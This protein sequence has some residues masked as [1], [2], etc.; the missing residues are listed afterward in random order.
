MI[1]KLLKESDPFLLVAI[2]IL[3]V[4]GIFLIYSA[5]D[6]GQSLTIG[7]LYAR[8]AIWWGIALFVGAISFSIPLKWWEA[9]AYPLYAIGVISLIF[10]ALKSG[11]GDLSTRWVDFGPFNIQPSEFAKIFTVMAC[12]R[13]LGNRKTHIASLGGL[14]VP[15][16]LVCI[17]AALVAL[18]P[19]LGTAIVF[20][21]ILIAILFWSGLPLIYLLFLI[22]PVTSFLLIVF[23]TEMESFPWIVYRTTGGEVERIITL[24]FCFGIGLFGLVVIYFALRKRLQFFYSLLLLVVYLATGFL[25]GPF[26]EQLKP[27]QRARI[28][29]FLRPETD[30]LGGGWQIIQSKVAIGS[31]GLIGKGF[32]EGTQKKLAFLPAQHTDFIFSILGEEFGYIGVVLFLALFLFA[33]I[34][35]VE[36]ARNVSQNPFSTLLVFG[37]LAIWFFHF[38]INVGMTLGIMPVTGLPLPFLSYG[39]SFLVACYFTL[40]ILLRISTERFQYWVGG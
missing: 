29:G 26:W 18:Q 17:P 24:W 31:G 6:G 14:L 37:F 28:L 15:A 5:G 7:D 21:V 23:A 1:G 22:I 36:L 40:G 2:A 35:I 3:T 33:L 11:A 4:L 19:D 10:L 9:S 39:G 27:Y 16:F 13:Y 25:T 32:L 30:P 20:I 34:R 38:L 8:Q 12:A